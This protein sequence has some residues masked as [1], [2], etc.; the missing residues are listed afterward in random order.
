MNQNIQDNS[1]VNNNDD[2]NDDDK[3]CDSLPLLEKSSCK[4]WINEGSNTINSKDSNSNG[5]D[6]RSATKFERGYRQTFSNLRRS[7]AL[8]ILIVFLAGWLDNFLLTVV[9]PIVPQYIA[10]LDVRSMEEKTATEGMILTEER[11]A[12]LTAMEVTA[13]EQQN[14]GS[15]LLK[16]TMDKIS[17]T[18]MH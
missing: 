3:T 5:Y 15:G 8:L 9:V 10:E 1:K 4:S 6:Y 7:N 16:A 12:I 18:F 17:G 13:M 2:D 14:H 11:K